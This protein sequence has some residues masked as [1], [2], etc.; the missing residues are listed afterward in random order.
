MHAPLPASGTAGQTL[1]TNILA[2]VRR[3]IVFETYWRLSGAAGIDAGAEQ[4]L[5]STYRR[6]SGSAGVGSGNTKKKSFQRTGILPTQPVRV[7]G[8]AGA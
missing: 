3:R 4:N 6:L 1:I 8:D 5:I 7:S 2:I